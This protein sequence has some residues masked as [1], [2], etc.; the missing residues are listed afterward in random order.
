MPRAASCCSGCSCDEAAISEQNGL[1]GGHE[2]DARGLFVEDSRET[3]RV[4]HV[5][6]IGERNRI[7]VLPGK[8]RTNR[9]EW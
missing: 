5:G 4:A 3:G 6:H 8:A 9:V 2:C 1:R 7:D